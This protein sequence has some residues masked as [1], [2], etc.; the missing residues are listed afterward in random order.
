[1]ENPEQ[2]WPGKAAFVRIKSPSALV[3]VPA[4][5]YYLFLYMADEAV[6]VYF[7]SKA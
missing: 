3:E 2:K 1:M 6:P 7:F 4:T 5:K